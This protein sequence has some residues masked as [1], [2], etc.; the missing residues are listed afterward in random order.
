MRIYGIYGKLCASRSVL[1]TGGTFLSLV[2]LE[3]DIIFDCDVICHLHIFYSISSFTLF[4][5]WNL[6]IRNLLD[7]IKEKKNCYSLIYYRCNAVVMYFA[8]FS[9]LSSFIHILV[10]VFITQSNSFYFT[11]YTLLTQDIRVSID[12]LRSPVL[13]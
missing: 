9:S 1:R 8:Q 11:V 3:S 12:N 2:F 10:C 13:P 5:H 4:V 6:G 7:I